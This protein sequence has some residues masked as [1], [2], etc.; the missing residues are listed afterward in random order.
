MDN[1]VNSYIREIEGYLNNKR[2]M[3]EA[4]GRRDFIPLIDR[5]VQ[6]VRSI[7]YPLAPETTSSMNVNEQGKS[8]SQHTFERPPEKMYHYAEGEAIDCAI[9]IEQVEAKHAQ[10]EKYVKQP[11]TWEHPLSSP[12]TPQ[13]LSEPN[14]MP[15]PGEL[16]FANFQRVLVFKV[17]LNFEGVLQVVN[18]IFGGRLNLGH[19][20]RNDNGAE[21]DFF[22][23]EDNSDDVSDVDQVDYEPRFEGVHDH[24]ENYDS[25]SDDESNSS[26]EDLEYD[27]NNSHRYR[28][29]RNS[30]YNGSTDNLSMQGRRARLVMHASNSRIDDLPDGVGN[31]DD[32]DNI[33]HRQQ[34]RESRSILRERRERD[35]SSMRSCSP[36]LSR[37]RSDPP[38]NNYHSYYLEREREDSRRVSS[39][40]SEMDGTS[41]SRHD[42]SS[43]FIEHA[44]Q[45]LYERSPSYFER[46]ISDRSRSTSTVLEELQRPNGL[47][48]RANDLPRYDDNA[49]R[50]ERRNDDDP[51]GSTPSYVRGE[52]PLYNNTNRLSFMNTLPQTI[53][54]AS[55]NSSTSTTYGTQSD[56]EYEFSNALYRHATTTSRLR[57]MYQDDST[58]EEGIDSETS[59][60]SSEHSEAEDD[61]DDDEVMFTGYRRCFSRQS[62]SS[63]ESPIFSSSD[64]EDE[65]DAASVATTASNISPPRSGTDQHWYKPW[66]WYANHTTDSKSTSKTASRESTVNEVDSDATISSGD[67]LYS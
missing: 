11:R 16:D 66:S 21:E 24:L 38:R 46:P 45:M 35:A 50:N 25:D 44:T 12:P 52:E 60:S 27:Q 9:C 42:S 8:S 40:D 34:G 10:V 57:N 64:G 41:L 4:E 36:S 58:T 2:I 59:S 63:L 3:C 31:D 14:D 17:I 62:T 53:L 39:R 26:E 55:Q 54:N 43:S 22:D 23:N 18:S 29:H 5:T 51:R 1:I 33:D 15:H 13:N 30:Q 47:P 7:K 37:H 49:R 20:F 56:S 6:M 48:Q 28:S 65:D 32:Q 61:Q 19:P 67:E